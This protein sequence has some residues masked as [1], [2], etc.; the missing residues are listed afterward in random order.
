MIGEAESLPQGGTAAISAKEWR[1]V[2]KVVRDIHDGKNVDVHDMADAQN[3][4]TKGGYMQTAAAIGVAI[5]KKAVP[6]PR[7]APQSAPP[8]AFMVQ[9]MPP[10]PAK[11][12][13]PPKKPIL[14][15]VITIKPPEPEPAPVQQG[16]LPHTIM[17]GFFAAFVGIGLAV[18]RKR[19]A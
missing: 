3:I 11:H 2:Q 5:T 9:K 8:P 19:F 10:K 17:A 14:A 12:H 1:F 13:A 16:I 6:P 18:E 4:A 15:A 7:P